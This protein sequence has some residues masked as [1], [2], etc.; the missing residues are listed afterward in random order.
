ME[1]SECALC[2]C[3]RSV[4]TC[5]R[6]TSD[7]LQQRRTMLMALQAD[8]AVLRKKA[9]FALN[10]KNGL[11]DAEHRLDACMKRVEA[12]ADKVMKTREKLCS[13]RI[14][15]VERTTVFERR[16]ERV[17]QDQHRLDQEQLIVKQLHEPVLECLD[18]QISWADENVAHVRGDKIRELFSLFGL[19][20]EPQQSPEDPQAPYKNRGHRPHFRTIALLP[21][22]ISG[23]YEVMPPE[24][25]AGALGKIIHLLTLIAKHVRATYP[26]PMVYN[27]SFSTIG[28]TNEGAGCHTLYP[29]GSVGFDRGVAM[30]HENVV[31]LGSTQGIP[32]HKLHRS[33]LLGNLLQIYQSP[34]LG[35]L[36]EHVTPAETP[37]DGSIMGQSAFFVDSQSLTTSTVILPDYSMMKR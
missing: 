3:Q 4:F 36:A 14:A 23:R 22:P 30:L 6:C 21:L 16:S 27:G 10:S 20:P 7:M 35:T 24:V 11:V 13:E 29:D 19:V 37:D 12:M 31:Y 28:N 2:G 9:E 18:L 32:E 33:D 34:A 15:L 5:A 1:R 26:H 8:V 17:E 25:V